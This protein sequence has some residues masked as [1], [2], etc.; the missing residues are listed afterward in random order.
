MYVRNFCL[1]TVAVPCVVPSGRLV[2]HIGITSC[3]FPPWK[4]MSKKNDY[5]L[6]PLF[7]VCTFSERQVHFS[8]EM[9]FHLLC[10]H[11]SLHCSKESNL[12]SFPRQLQYL[13]GWHVFVAELKKYFRISVPHLVFLQTFVQIESTFPVKRKRKKGTFLH[14]QINPRE[15]RS[16]EIMYRE[17]STSRTQSL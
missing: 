2:L 13:N 4:E 1:L 12:F 16:Q 6:W 8:T 7:L 15:N 14:D 11:I 17:L 9:N 5:A 10:P 3:T